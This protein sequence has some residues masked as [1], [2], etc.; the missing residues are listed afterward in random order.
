MKKEYDFSDPQTRK[1][2]IEAV[3]NPKLPETYEEFSDHPLASWIESNLGLSKD[4]ES[5]RL[6]RS[7]PRSLKGE[8]S[9]GHE[10]SQVTQLEEERCV[11]VIQQL[12]LRGNLIKDPLTKF[13]AFAFRLHQFISRGDTVY[14]SIEDESKRYF[15]YMGK[16][17][18][19]E[20]R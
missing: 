8:G 4:E 5:A 3:K 1:I 9:I 6:V 17:W 19:L 13:P 10:L 18:C 14:A 16:N 20:S 15:R 12:L 2:L 11:Q 7:Q